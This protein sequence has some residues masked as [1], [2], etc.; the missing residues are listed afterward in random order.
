MVSKA[1]DSYIRNVL[2]IPK[3]TFRDIFV[4]NI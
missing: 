2:R 3:E 1:F 4:I